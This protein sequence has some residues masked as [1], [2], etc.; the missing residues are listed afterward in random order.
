M[1]WGVDDGLAGRDIVRDF[2]LD[3]RCQQPPR[4]LPEHVGQHVAG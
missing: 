1:P 4:P 2:G 3:H